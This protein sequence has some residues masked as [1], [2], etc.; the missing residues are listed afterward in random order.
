M[1]N[2]QLFTEIS[3]TSFFQQ[4]FLVVMGM[5]GAIFTDNNILAKKI[6]IRSHGSINKKDYDIQGVS[7]R[8]DTLQSSILLAKLKYLKKYISSFK[9]SF[10]IR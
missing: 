5:V 1:E 4:K 2:T 3:C 6:K 9:N 8:M 7:G 10:N